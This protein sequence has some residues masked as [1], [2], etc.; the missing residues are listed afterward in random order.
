MRPLQLSQISQ[1]VQEI[2]GAEPVELLAEPPSAWHY[3][4]VTALSSILTGGFRLSHIHTM[5]DP[6]ELVTDGLL[7]AGDALKELDLGQRSDG[8][9]HTAK[10][11]F[12]S[13]IQEV[14][15]LSFSELGDQPLMWR[16]YGDTGAGVA[17]KVD[18][19]RLTNLGV[20]NGGSKRL[21]LAF[22]CRYVES[23]EEQNHQYVQK[24]LEALNGV[25]LRK[26]EEA[27]ARARELIA[28]LFVCLASTKLSILSEEKE[29]R[30]L[31]IPFERQGK[32][33]CIGNQLRKVYTWKDSNSAIEE[34]KRGPFNLSER[35]DF[36][37]EELSQRKG[38]RLSK[39]KSPY[40]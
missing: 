21:N 5:N 16:R 19:T 8:T 38:F 6:R 14:Y 39:S 35:H 18:A 24:F 13:A 2:S 11:E 3:T 37:Y 32:V 12:E 17:L 20:L 33:E 10:I 22:R 9:R 31:N 29:I 1:F 4:S 36:L 7:V 26:N 15:V 25:G 27:Q 28:A 30:I 34:V 40:C 23:I